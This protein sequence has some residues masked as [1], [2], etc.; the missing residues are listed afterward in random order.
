MIRHQSILDELEKKGYMSV[1]ELCDKFKVSSV[2]IRKDLKLLEKKG[3]LFKTH[4]GA[5]IHN[6]YINERNVSE[7]ENINANEKKAI[8]QEAIKL[9]KP[10]DDIMIG[11]GTSM[12]ALAHELKMDH[13]L[14]IITSSLNVSIEL[15]RYPRFNILQLGGNVRHSSSSVTGYFSTSVLK[16]ISCNLL[17]LGVDG[18]DLEFG[19]TT[20]S[21]EEA[22]LNQ[23]MIASAQK[24]IVLADSSKF[25]KKG[26]GKICDIPSINHI[27]TDSAINNEV[28]HEL[29][30]RG[31]EV[32]VVNSP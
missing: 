20:T 10:N 26:F 28:V 22:I 19:C 14:N 8:A 7:K 2:T 27:I 25:N 29:K 21:I 17:F 15:T 9:I 23:N 6:P 13:D 30:G 16:N 11:S 1:S 24:V 18:I 32:T 3:L 12:Q 4:G 5:S 31:V